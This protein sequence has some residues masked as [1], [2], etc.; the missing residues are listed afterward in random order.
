V[1]PR[2]DI[3]GRIRGVPVRKVTVSK[4]GKLV[5]ADVTWNQ[6]LIKRKGNRDRFNV[7]VVV[8]PTGG[9]APIVLTNRSKTKTPPRVQKI[10]IKLSKNKA[11]KLRAADDAVLTVSQQHGKTRVSVSIGRM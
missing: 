5:T 2:G 7:R 6:G 1:S 3:V 9:G 10:R 8:F 4:R 11:K